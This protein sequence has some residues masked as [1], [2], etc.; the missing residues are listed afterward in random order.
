VVNILDAN[1]LTSDYRSGAKVNQMDLGLKLR[2]LE[3]ELDTLIQ[4]FKQ[5]RNKEKLSAFSVKIIVLVLSAISTILLGLHLKN[6]QLRDL[7]KNIAFVLG[8][9]IGLCNAL[10]A[11][12]DFRALW[13]KRSVTLARLYT[14]Q[15][16]LSFYVLGAGTDELA[17]KKL[18]DFKD[19]INMILDEDIKVWLKLSEQTETKAINENQNGNQNQNESQSGNQNQS[20][21]QPG[22]Q[23]Q[24]GSQPG[25][26]NGNQN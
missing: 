1:S 15:R 25:N 23:N 8:V 5:M 19:Q 9:L 22:N 18:A 20:G 24:S 3:L 26:Q 13:L 14:I 17:E 6:P 21:S 4:R 2:Y 7:F 12:C 11:F 16:N 10:E